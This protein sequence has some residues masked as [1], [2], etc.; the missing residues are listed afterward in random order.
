[1][2]T[3]QIHRSINN[4][5]NVLAS[6]GIMYQTRIKGKVL[7]TDEGEYNPIAVGD[8]VTIEPYASDEALLISREGRKSTFTRFNAKTGQNQI[9]AAN[10]DM[11]AIILSSE[12]PPFRPRFVDRAIACASASLEILLVMNKCDY[13]LTEEEF[14]RWALY[15]KLG[16]HIIAVSAKTGENLPDLSRILKGK[17]TA[18]VGQSGVG[19]SSLVNALLHPSEE[20]VTGEVCEKYQRG[21]HTTN[22]ALFL[23]GKDFALIDTPGVRELL[24]PKEDPQALSYS[25]PEFRNSGCAYAHCL[26]I[27]EPGCKVKEMVENGEIHPDRYESYVH[28]IE[29]LEERTPLWM[30]DRKRK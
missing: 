29:S 4:I 21:R 14:E 11:V 23:Q 20:Q 10:M 27:D 18:F 3:G 15:H 13:L 24:V 1:M 5:Y 17:V 19:K 28:M 12:S 9:M 26:H 25:F 30:R 22:H 8:I 7:K 6:D 16:Y 2:L